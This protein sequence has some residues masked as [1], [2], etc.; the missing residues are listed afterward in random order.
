VHEFTVRPFGPNSYRFLARLVVSAKSLRFV[1]YSAAFVAIST[2][3]LDICRRSA[4]KTI[5]RSG[6]ACIL[7]I[8]LVFNGRFEAAQ[9]G[10]AMKAACNSH[11][12]K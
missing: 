11:G 12:C 3:S 9:R 5:K 2:V 10:F 6:K 4:G 7:R 1:L 8:E